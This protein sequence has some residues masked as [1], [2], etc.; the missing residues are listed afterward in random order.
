MVFQASASE[1]EKSER[2]KPRPPFLP[3]LLADT[4]D[5]LGENAPGP[6][7][8]PHRVHAT[9]FRAL[10]PQFWARQFG[11]KPQQHYRQEDAKFVR[12]AR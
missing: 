8:Y 9:L 3:N 2:F 5:W 7:K 4:A 1:A 12:P 10:T 6:L 11:H